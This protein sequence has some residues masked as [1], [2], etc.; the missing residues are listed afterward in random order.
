MYLQDED[1]TGSVDF[2]LSDGTHLASIPIPR[3]SWDDG[4]HT[5][6]TATNVPLTE[7]QATG[8]LNVLTHLNYVTIGH[9]AMEFHASVQIGFDSAS[10]MPT[11]VHCVATNTQVGPCGDACGLFGCD[12][13][14]CPKDLS[15][16]PIS[17]GVSTAPGLGCC[18]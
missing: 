18:A 16:F 13:N 6:Q 4:K 1:S 11:V 10:Q 14:H 12:T 17:S 3:G 5:L 2:S 15:P 9:D 8:A 7:D